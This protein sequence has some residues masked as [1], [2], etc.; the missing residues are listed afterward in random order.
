MRISNDGV[1]RF[2]SKEL[3]AREEQFRIYYRSF[4]GSQPRGVPRVIACTVFSAIGQ[5]TRL[6]V[7]EFGWTADDAS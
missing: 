3:N 7:L 2:S 6:I 1:D 5:S 4:S